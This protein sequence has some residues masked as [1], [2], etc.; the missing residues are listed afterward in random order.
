MANNGRRDLGYIAVGTALISGAIWFV[1]TRR[2]GGGSPPPDGDGDGEP[3][4]VGQLRLLGLP[5][6]AVNSD[7]LVVGPGGTLDLQPSHRWLGIAVLSQ[8]QNPT[9]QPLLLNR[10]LR[11]RRRL[12]LASDQDWVIFDPGR[13]VVLDIPGPQIQVPSFGGDPQAALIDPGAVVDLGHLLFIGGPGLSTAALD[14]WNTFDFNIPLIAD[15]GF[16]LEVAYFQ[17]P[18]PG[19][20]RQEGVNLG[21]ASWGGGSETP[22]FSLEMNF[23]LG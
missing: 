15:L 20:L 2:R 19:A 22:A 3:P 10:H 8:W 21:G 18:R 11:L 9:S 13:G 4:P 14:F 6:L 17:M 12:S 16:N 1:A 7:G 5:Q 23:G